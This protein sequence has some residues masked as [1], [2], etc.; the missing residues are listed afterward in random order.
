MAKIN[1]ARFK[2]RVVT[3]HNC[4]RPKHFKKA[5]EKL[6]WSQRLFTSKTL[7]PLVHMHVADV[8][9]HVYEI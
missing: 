2:V 7:R 3:S 6:K 8:Y 5:P 4:P 1:T 9:T